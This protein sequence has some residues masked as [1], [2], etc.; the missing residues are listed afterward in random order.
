[1]LHLIYTKGEKQLINTSEFYLYV[2][3]QGSHLF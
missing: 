1:M 3:I 2:I